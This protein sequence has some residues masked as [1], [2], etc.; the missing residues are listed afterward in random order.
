VAVGAA[1][2]VEEIAAVGEGEVVHRLR[3]LVSL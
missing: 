1:A 3:L 2:V